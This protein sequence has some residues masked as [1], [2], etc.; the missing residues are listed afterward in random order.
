MFISV[1][2]IDL[3]WTELWPGTSFPLRFRSCFGDGG[4]LWRGFRFG[5]DI[6]LGSVGRF[7]RAFLNDAA[8]TTPD[9][10]EVALVDFAR[11]STFGGF[12]PWRTRWPATA[13]FSFPTSHR[14]VD[15]VHGNTS[16]GRA[17]SKPSRPSGFTQLDE[18]VVAVRYGSDCGHTI[19]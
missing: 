4:F 19:Q 5:H 9:D 1:A 11:L 16:Y 8:I 18:L 13:R 12:S 3:Q 7:F 6:V 10:Q 17:T 15:R 14:M 2:E